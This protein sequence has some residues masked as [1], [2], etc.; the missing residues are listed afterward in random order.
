MVY[1]RLDHENHESRRLTSWEDVKACGWTTLFPTL[2]DFL[3]DNMPYKNEAAEILTAID[4]DIYGDTYNKNVLVGKD[5]WLFYRGDGC[6]Q[7]YRGG[8]VMKEDELKSYADSARKLC[9]AAAAHGIDV[10]L[11]ITPNKEMIYGDRY[12]PDHV[13]RISDVSRADQIVGYLRDNTDV[14]V[15]YPKDALIAASDKY[16]VWLKYDTHWNDIGAFVGSME[17]LDAMGLGC[18][19]DISEVEVTADGFRGGDLANMLGRAGKYKDDINY[20]IEGYRDDIHVETVENIDQSNLSFTIMET[21]RR[22]DRED[23]WV[24]DHEQAGDE[25]DDH[26]IGKTILYIGDSFLGSMERYVSKGADRSIFIHRENYEA[27]GRDII[28]DEK[29]DI[30]VLQTAERFIGGYGDVM[31]RYAGI[32]INHEK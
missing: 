31:D 8:L 22:S 24:I 9:D 30:I 3:D 1:G 12:M 4:K 11:M 5:D 21:Q 13:R 29:P 17:L 7:D 27:L 16:Q 15:V 19:E 6:I 2:Q 32:I 14:K 18:A 26:G 10:Y 23:T 20:V 25:K 28:A